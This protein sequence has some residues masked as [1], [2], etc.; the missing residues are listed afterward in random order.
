M[1][2]IVVRARLVRESCAW[3]RSMP[4]DS[5]NLW[6]QILN[7]QSER[8]CNLCPQCS[9]DVSKTYLAADAERQ[10]DLNFSAIA[11]RSARRT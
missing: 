5:N 4:C 3:C 8:I 2:V 11:G 1:K 10:F 9:K 6:C 7:D